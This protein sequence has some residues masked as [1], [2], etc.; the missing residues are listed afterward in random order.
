MSDARRLRAI[1]QFSLNKHLQEL[2]VLFSGRGPGPV[3]TPLHFS[4][5]KEYYGPM[6]KVTPAWELW[7]CAASVSA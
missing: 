6:G 1:G 5:D 3:Y 7:P 2:L 4:G